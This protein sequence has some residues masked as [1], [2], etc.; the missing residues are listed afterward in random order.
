MQPSACKVFAPI[1]VS[2]GSNSPAAAAQ[3]EDI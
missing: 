1:D 2:N 3:N